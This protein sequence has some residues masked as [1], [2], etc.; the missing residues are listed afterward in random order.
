M[1]R[2]GPG[3]RPVSVASLVIVP[4]VIP[5]V[6]MT[7]VP[8]PICLTTFTVGGFPLEIPH[9]AAGTTSTRA[10]RG[11]GDPVRSDDHGM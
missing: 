6:S 4:I 3:R 9:T 2:F 10:G 8:N 5:L 7:L 11:V 1:V